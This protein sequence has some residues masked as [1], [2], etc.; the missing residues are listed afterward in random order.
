MKLLTRPTALLGLRGLL[1]DLL[2]E[3]A[4]LPHAESNK[5]VSC[6]TSAFAF[7]ILYDLTKNTGEGDLRTFHHQ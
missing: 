6:L 1:N 5:V 4:Y 2:E 3:L 7:D